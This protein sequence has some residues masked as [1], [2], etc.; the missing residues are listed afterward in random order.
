MASRRN[1]KKTI[2]FAT[3]EIINE[4]YFHCLMKKNIVE[5]KVENLVKEAVEL[6]REF[7]LRANHPDGKDNRQKVKAYYKKLYADW[8]TAMI[9]IIAKKDKL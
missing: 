1:L 3:S 8:Q 9:N 2:Q 4:I 5:E 6:N 7:V